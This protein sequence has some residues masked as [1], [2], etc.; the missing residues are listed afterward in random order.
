VAHSH[1]YDEN[2]FNDLRKMLRAT[3]RSACAVKK[4]IEGK[5]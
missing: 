3:A 1:D 2:G 5:G 4:E